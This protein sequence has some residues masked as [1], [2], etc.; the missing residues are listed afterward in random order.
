MRRHEKE[1]TLEDVDILAA[2]D[3]DQPFADALFIPVS[4]DT[5]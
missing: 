1:H 3:A 5:N 2:V 4:A